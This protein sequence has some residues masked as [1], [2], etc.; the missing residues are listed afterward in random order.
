[1]ALTPDLDL[2]LDSGPDRLCDLGQISLSEL[3]F[4]VLYNGVNTMGS[5]LQVSMEACP[6][7]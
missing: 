3:R 6:A 1:M 2:S 5:V 7:T 4:P